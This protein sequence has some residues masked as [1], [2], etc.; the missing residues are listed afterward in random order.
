MAQ[1]CQIPLQ[2]LDVEAV[3]NPAIGALTDYWC[4]LAAGK[5]PDRTAFDFMKIYKTAPNL[6]M[7]ERVA[8]ETFKFIYCGTAVAEN[9]PR[10]LTGATYGPMTPR[11]SRIEW[12]GIFKEVLDAPCMRYGRERIDWPNDEHRDI[13]YAA[14]PLLGKDGRPTYVVTCLVFVLRSPFDPRQL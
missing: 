8:P 13:I 4:T 10:D 1:N 2:V 6:L 11:V 3:T 5:P 14:C 9:F 7:A 12:G